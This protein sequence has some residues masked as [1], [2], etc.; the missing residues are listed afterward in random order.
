MVFWGKIVD[1]IELITRVGTKIS[2]LKIACKKLSVI[3]DV[4]ATMD[5][6]PKVLY[7]I[8][9]WSSGDSSWTMVVSNH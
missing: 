5:C 4:R 9:G 6:L 1:W 3:T 2:V 7:M 8:L